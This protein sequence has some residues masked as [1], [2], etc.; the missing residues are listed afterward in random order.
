MTDSLRIAKQIFADALELPADKRL[1]FIKRSAHGDEDLERRVLDL[2]KAH[3]EAGTFLGTP[4][5]HPREQSPP[6]EPGSVAPEPPQQDVE[7]QSSGESTIGHYHIRRRIGEGHYGEVFEAEQTAP[8]RRRV[9]IKVLKRGVDTNQ[10][11]ARF[12]AERQAIATLDHPNLCRFLDAGQTADGRP[13]FV[14]DLVRGPNIR[15]YCDSN[16]LSIHDRVQLL[17]DACRGVDHA[18][19]TGLVHRD[20]KPSNILVEV[21]DDHAVPQVIDFGIARALTGPITSTAPGTIH[22]QM[23]GTP[24]YMSP[25]QV[26]GQMDID[27]RSDVY[28]LGCVLFE[29]LTGS[30]PI[31]RADLVRMPIGEMQQ[32]VRDS[33]FTPPSEVLESSGS[34]LQTIARR[35]GVDSRRLPN[36]VRGEL[37]WICEKALARDKTDRYANAG[38]LA[39]DLQRWLDGR[40][41][42][43]RPRHM[44][45]AKARRFFRQQRTRLR[46]GIMIAAALVL[47][48]AL[49]AG[50]I[51]GIPGVPQFMERSMEHYASGRR[52]GLPEGAW[53]NG[54]RVNRVGGKYGLV[55]GGREN[56]AASDF[57]MVGGG[58]GN[59]A[60]GHGSAVGGGKYNV[61][62]GVSAVVA[63]G[64]MNIIRGPVATIAGGD[65]NQVTSGYGTVGGGQKNRVTGRHATISGG[66]ENRVFDQNGS[67]G[68]GYQNRI[69][70]DDAET[71]QADAATIGG[72]IKNLALWRQATVGGGYVNN[73]LSDWTTVA[74][75]AG[76]Q[77][78]SGDRFV[79]SAATVGGG[80]K[81]KATG[82]N[83]AIPG[84]GWNEASGEGSLAAGTRARATHDG[85]FTWSDLTAED[86]PP[87]TSDAPNS[88][89]A[90]ARGGFRFLTSLTDGPRLKPGQGGWSSLLA[91]EHLTPSQSTEPIDILGGIRHL[92][93]RRYRFAAEQGGRDHLAPTAEQFHQV[94]GLGSPDGQV[95]NT[96]LDGVALLAIQQLLDRIKEQQVQIEQ[97]NQRIKAIEARSAEK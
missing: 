85:S 56:R 24:G 92:E 95:L 63:G 5:H 49:L 64:Q 94:F 14:M 47:I 34:A 74:G 91:A 23:M 29:L 16:R 59:I 44:I 46:R 86:E 77:S 37:D 70:N 60:A 71:V 66:L 17:I 12:H 89:T 36:L 73:A 61:A 53:V 13:Y 40:S 10:T 52:I 25:E 43:A 82:T 57:S 8:I 42:T 7:P 3:E 69:G 75:G 80:Q 90:R 30:T 87:V 58:A 18:H 79:G 41:V 67:I 31:P 39:D 76:N 33:A 68:G 78:G 93:I 50:F 48:F 19:R 28:S 84:G 54:I 83:S 21:R 96:D 20:L 81:N 4:T 51:P 11:L 38:E 65:Q 15:E 1:A 97:L 9:A 72:G 27:P 88:F 55:G 6:S 26:A 62:E 22:G 35:R 2:L 45:G 32:A